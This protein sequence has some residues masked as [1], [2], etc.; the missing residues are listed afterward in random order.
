M[1]QRPEQNEYAAY[2][3]RYISKVDEKGSEA[4]LRSTQFLD[5]IT[6]F[7]VAQWDYSYAPGKWTLRQVLV[8]LM[9][10]ER[11]FAYRALR[12]S[13]NDMT[14]LPGFEQ[15]GYVDNAVA[16]NRSADSLIEEYKSVRAATLSLFGQLNAE[17]LSRIGTAGDA[18]TSVRAL[19]YMIAGHELHHQEL[20]H[21]HYL[22]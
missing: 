9:D 3:D 22:K 1:N 20:I 17:A 4:V 7:T 19:A 18:A 13:R 15:D 2:F 8:H 11:I 21:A 10:T 16:E 5:L 6:G 14:A 12:I